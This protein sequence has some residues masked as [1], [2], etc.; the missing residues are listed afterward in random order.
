MVHMASSWR[1]HRVKA[2]NRYVDAMG[3]IGPFYLNFVV[4]YVLGP[5]GILVFLV[6]YLGL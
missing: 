5:R 6:F 3:C 1:L 4:F 2:E